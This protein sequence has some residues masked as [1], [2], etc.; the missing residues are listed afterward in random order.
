MLL[1]MYGS[2]Q[3]VSH[4]LLRNIWWT[5]CHMIHDYYQYWVPQKCIQY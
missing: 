3:N 1:L 4:F 5:Q 2:D